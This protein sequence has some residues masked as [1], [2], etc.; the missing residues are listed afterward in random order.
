MSGGEATIQIFQLASLSQRVHIAYEV[1]RGKKKDNSINEKET[2]KKA[3]EKETV[4]KSSHSTKKRKVKKGLVR[5]L[6]ISFLL[7]LET[8]E[9]MGEG[10]DF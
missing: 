8:W 4:K 7:S 10:R 2:Q 9:V 3:K 1:T 6:D 5:C